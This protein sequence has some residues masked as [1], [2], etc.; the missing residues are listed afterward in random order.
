ME[1]ILWYVITLITVALALAF[2]GDT[3]IQLL[4]RDDRMWRC[5]KA[6]RDNVRITF[7]GS[8]VR[9]KILTMVPLGDDGYELH[10]KTTAPPYKDI[11]RNVTAMQLSTDDIDLMHTGRGTVTFIEDGLRTITDEEYHK[12]MNLTNEV[13]ALQGQIA[14]LESAQRGAVEDMVENVVKMAGSQ[15]RGGGY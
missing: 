9:Y 14:T 12:F 11:V 10:C 2:G 13:I 1:P 3:I 15:N 6:S 5:A 8:S 7:E 4:T